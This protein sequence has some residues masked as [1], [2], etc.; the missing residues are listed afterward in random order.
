MK[1]SIPF[2]LTIVSILLLLLYSACGS[3]NTFED[4][5]PAVDEDI[6]AGENNDLDAGTDAS[7]HGD[8]CSDDNPWDCNPVADYSADP[9]VNEGCSGTNVS[10]DYWEP[11]SG[12]TCLLDATEALGDTC[13]IDNGPWCTTGATCLATGGASNGI[14]VKF[15]CGAQDCEPLEDC[16][17]GNWPNVTGDLG[18]CL[19]P[20]S[21]PDGGVDAG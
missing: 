15:C 8:P 12:F 3:V 13:D 21:D 10:C 7:V 18:Y 6:G 14:C 19:A 1:I 17:Q 4:F 5:E 9:P 16:N 11:A 20:G 2:E